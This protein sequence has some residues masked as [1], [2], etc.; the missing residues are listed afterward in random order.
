MNNR[1]GGTSN[2]EQDEHVVLLVIAAVFIFAFLVWARFGVQITGLFVFVRNLWNYPLWHLY[3]WLVQNTNSDYPNLRWM[4][5]STVELCHP[6]DLY[7]IWDCANNFQNVKFKQLSNSSVAFN[8]VFGLISVGLGMKAHMRISEQHPANKYRRKFNVKQF[9]VEQIP[10]QPHLGLYSKFDYSA[11]DNNSGWLMGLQTSKEYCMSNDLFG[12]PKGRTV[13]VI[14]KGVVQSQTNN[15]DKIPTIRK[16][17]LIAEL[18][19]QLGS[20]WIDLDHITPLEAI[21]LAMYLPKACCLDNTMP[22]EEFYAIEKERAS[23]ENEL[24]DIAID[25][26]LNKDEKGNNIPDGQFNTLDD[27]GNFR[28]FNWDVSDKDKLPNLNAFPIEDYKR[29]YIKKYLNYKIAKEIF[30]KHAYTRSIIF[31][32]VLHARKLGVLAPCQMRWIRFYDRSMW[33]LLQSIGRPSFFCENMAAMSHYQAECVLGEK[34]YQPQFEVAISGLEAQILTYEFDKEFI[35]K[36][37]MRFNTNQDDEFIN[38]ES[39]SELDKKY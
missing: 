24:W 26:I 19:Y 34:I 18:K 36:L 9:M 37:E 39:K 8:I 1:P 31:S 20:L 17:P 5:S 7:N 30:S 28:G 4:I 32:V 3:V 16:E 6:R 33:A 10:N 21:L 2:L 11:F 23:F 25:E 29:I 27:E 14:N 15:I 35:D 12:R 22:D 38:Y 13:V